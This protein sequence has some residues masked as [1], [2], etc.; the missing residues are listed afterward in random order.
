MCLFAHFHFSV[1]TPDSE[2]PNCLGEWGSELKLHCRSEVWPDV[3]GAD[4]KGSWE[5]G[6]RDLRKLVW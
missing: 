6:H 4:S 3:S 2:T 5:P 1:V